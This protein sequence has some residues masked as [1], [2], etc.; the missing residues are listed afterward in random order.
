[1]GLAKK[2]EDTFPDRL[3]IFMKDGYSFEAF[4][5]EVYAGR[6]TLYRWCK[7]YPEFQEAREIGEAFALKFFEKLQ[8]MGAMGMKGQNKDGVDIRPN[9]GFVNFALSRRFREIYSEKQIVESQGETKT[10]LII[11]YGDNEKSTGGD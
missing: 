3:I 6:T 8:A 2:Y 9:P 5:A 4:G 1:M 11:D 7:E 10:R